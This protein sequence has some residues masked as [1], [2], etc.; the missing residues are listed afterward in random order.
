MKTETYQEEWNY[1]WIPSK[2]RTRVEMD[3][4]D[5][6]SDLLPAEWYKKDTLVY[7]IQ[8]KKIYK[9]KHIKGLK[10]IGLT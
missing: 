5:K 9:A 8:E 10:Y 7:I 6:L 1:E 3:A 4:Y 2:N